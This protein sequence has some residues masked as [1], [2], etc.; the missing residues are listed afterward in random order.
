MES[1]D[2]CFSKGS[3]VFKTASSIKRLKCFTQ[4]A[5]G[6]DFIVEYGD[7]IFPLTLKGMGGGASAHRRLMMLLS[8]IVR[9]VM[10]NECRTTK[11]C[12]K[13][14][15]NSL[16]M[17]CPKGNQFSENHKEYYHQHKA[18][19]FKSHDSFYQKNHGLSQCNNCN[20]L[21]SCDFMASLNICLSFVSYF[22]IGAVAEYLQHIRRL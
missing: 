21:W 13:C 2:S 9:I 8:K 7:G 6:D 10:T 4:E 15:D 22:Q 16:S 20:I 17:K 5:G 19:C 18:S 1:G 14:V 11:G 3:S 12:P